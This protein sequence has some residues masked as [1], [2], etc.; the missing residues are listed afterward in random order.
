MTACGNGECVKFISMKAWWLLPVYQRF[1]LA[2]AN[3]FFFKA[4]SYTFHK[5]IKVF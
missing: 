3:V 1:C 4:H 5:Y 2:M